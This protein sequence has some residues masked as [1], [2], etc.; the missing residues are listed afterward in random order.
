MLC[1]LESYLDNLSSICSKIET[2]RRDP[3]IISERTHPRES[4]QSLEI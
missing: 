1:H 2:I 3:L 4:N